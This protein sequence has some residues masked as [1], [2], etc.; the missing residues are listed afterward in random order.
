MIAG[1]SF[2]AHNNNPF[3][4]MMGHGAIFIVKP[5]LLSQMWIGEHLVNPVGTMEATRRSE[6][7]GRAPR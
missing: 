2:A 7:H 4:S 6:P 3:R 1:F 5:H